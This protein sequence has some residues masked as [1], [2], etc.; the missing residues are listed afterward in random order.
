M[1]PARAELLAVGLFLAAAAGPTLAGQKSGQAHAEDVYAEYA[2]GTG[3]QVAFSV[4]TLET[5]WLEQI[6]RTPFGELIESSGHLVES[7]QFGTELRHPRFVMATPVM[8][9]RP[10]LLDTAKGFEAAGYPIRQGTYRRLEVTTAIGADARKHQA[11]EFCWNALGHCVVLD[12]TVLFLESM[13]DNRRR[14]A[15]EGWGP[16]VVEE[17]GQDLGPTA[18]CG[19]ASNPGVTSRSLTWGG[20]TIEYKNIF[21]SVLIR[22]TMGAQQSGIRC[23]TGCAP[24]PFG[25][26]NASSCQGFLGWSCACDNDFG[27]GTTGGTGKWIAESKCTHKFAF[28]A[29]ASA[30]VTNV[31]SANVNI[32]WSLDGTPDAN[33]GQMMD[34][35]G[36]Y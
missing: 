26:G 7:Q 28:Q 1:H 29:S 5:G 13:V 14:L 35:C 21:G 19:L 11:M 24:A 31:G 20:Y 2:A 32:S 8:H 12:P 16:R 22:K 36:Y 30:S 17:H 9:L 10:E 23:T 25:Y 15:A 18:V 4:T 34:T 33:G 6:A 27:Y 3:H